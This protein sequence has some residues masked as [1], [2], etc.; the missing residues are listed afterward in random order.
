M[1][2]TFVIFLISTV[3][4]L[5]SSCGD[6]AKD[7]LPS[8]CIV[9]DID[10]NVYH[11]VVIG[12]QE[13][14]VEN[15]KTTRYRNGTAIPNVTDS[16]AW[17]GLTTGAYC[18]Y[19]NNAANSTT[20]G[21]LYNWYAVSNANNIAPTGWHVATDAEWTTLTTYLGGDSV[22]GGKLKEAGLAHWASSNTGATNETGFTALPGG[23]RGYGGTFGGIDNYGGWWSSTEDYTT[24]AW[25]RGMSDF[26]VNV[27]RISY[28]K[29]LGFSVRCVR[30]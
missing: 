27:L 13:W 4:G 21:R 7:E 25:S 26:N 6:D 11:I 15:L 30:D 3:I 19:N 24:I 16:T 9:T 20:Y 1:K 28:H 2:R 18:D 23:Y 29:P 22:A 14:L 8:G 5:V 12:T 17:S 10:G